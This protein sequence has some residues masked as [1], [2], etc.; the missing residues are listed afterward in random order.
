[1]PG[2]CVPSLPPSV[3]LRPALD[4]IPR[5]GPACRRGSPKSLGASRLAKGIYGPTEASSPEGSCL[6]SSEIIGREVISSQGEKLGT[7]YDVQFDEKGWNVLALGVQLEK[8]VADRYNLGHRFRKMGVMIEV[9][10]VQAVGDK[11]I[12]TGSSKE[13]L[14]LITPSA[15]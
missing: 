11:V 10:H 5:P 7:V 13:L 14:Q 8:D 12:L 2:G 6:L 1:M 15:P 3:S 9:K 4:R